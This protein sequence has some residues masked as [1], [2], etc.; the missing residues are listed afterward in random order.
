MCGVSSGNTQLALQIIKRNQLL[1]TVVQRV[2]P[3]SRKK[4]VQ[5]FQ[6]VQPIQL[7]SSFTQVQRKWASTAT[8][9]PP[10][11]S[12][13]H[14]SHS[15]T[16]TPHTPHTPPK[17]LDIYKAASPQQQELYEMQVWLLT[18]EER[19]ST[20]AVSM[21]WDQLTLFPFDWGICVVSTMKINFIY[22]M[23]CVWLLNTCSICC[24]SVK[25][26]GTFWQWS[27]EKNT[28]QTKNQNK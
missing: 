24:A 19:S 15:T 21:D 7:P 6:S 18:D 5:P 3:D 16:Q 25:P 26:I 20:A 8:S 22:C 27:T 23:M 11:P 12:S 9:D 13:S 2:S 10:R 14:S 17:S 4:T 28:V 1:P